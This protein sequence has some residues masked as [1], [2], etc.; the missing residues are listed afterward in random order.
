MTR[1]PT[2]APLE[3]HGWPGC[4]RLENGV[5]EA[6][7]VPAVGRVM[8]LR[9]LGEEGVFWENRDLFGALPDPASEEWANFGGDKAWPAPQSAWRR[10]FP[11]PP[12]FDT[13]PFMARRIRGVEGVGD[14][15]LLTSPVDPTLRLRIVRRI[16]LEPGEA[17]LRIE[18]SFEK[19]AG[20]P[21]EV[22]VWI[23]SQ[24]V[25]PAGVF[26]PLPEPSLFARGYDL[27]TDE[28]PPGLEVSG[29]ILSLRRSSSS[30]HKIGTDG[31][32]L[33]WVGERHALLVESPRLPGAPYPDNGCSVEVYTNDDPLAYVELE[34]LGPLVRLA[35]GERTSRVS[36]YRL[37]RRSEAA[38]LE[39]AR[40]VLARRRSLPDGVC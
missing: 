24:L 38:P 2:V 13:L 12:A 28:P 14:A 40:A 18:T 36:T 31:E 5:V 9:L 27:Q 25:D 34:T 6:F 39:E 20:T 33:V 19:T 32:N 21:V 4:L 1:P 23:V 16:E 8:Q 35:R 29:G 30:C 22:S 37:F 11:P 17:T 26:L 3:Y 7:V 15:V 10:H